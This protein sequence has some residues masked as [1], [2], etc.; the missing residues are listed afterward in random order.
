MILFK[1]FLLIIIIIIIYI[2][3]YINTFEMYTCLEEDYCVATAEGPAVGV[4]KID[5]GFFIKYVLGSTITLYEK[6]EDGTTRRTLYTNTGSAEN[7]KSTYSNNN[8]NNKIYFKNDTTPVSR[9]AGTP[10]NLIFN[11]K[12]YNLKFNVNGQIYIVI[13]NKFKTC[14]KI[15]Y[16]SNDSSKSYELSECDGTDNDN[17]LLLNNLDNFEKNMLIPQ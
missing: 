17:I 5:L 14:D 15:S 11:V 7:S 8:N 3:K 16:M 10:P 13:P 4:A 12:D 2:I 6:L 1:L 9:V